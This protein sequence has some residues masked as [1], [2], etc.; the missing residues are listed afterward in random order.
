MVGT[1]NYMAPEQLRGE[2]SD[3]RADIFSFGVVLYELLGGKKRVPGRLVRFDDATRSST[4][5]RSRSIGSIRRCRRSLT[6]IVD[7]RSPSRATIA[8]ST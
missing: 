5:R 8:T 4:R 1:V 2:K 3:H 6:A 7:R